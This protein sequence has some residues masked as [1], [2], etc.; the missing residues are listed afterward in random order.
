MEEV[1]QLVPT[2][3]AGDIAVRLI[4]ILALVGANGFFV[5]SEFALVGARRTR[6]DMLAEQGERSARLAQKAIRHLDH[7]LS[8]TQLGITLASLGLGW[9]GETT[10][11]SLFMQ[12]FQGLPAPWDVIATHAVA[13]TI[14]F[15][16]IT[17]LHIVL[18]ELAPKS[19]AILHPE[20]VS[21]WTAGPLIAFSIVLSPFIRALNGLAG[22]LLR[23]FGLS[24]PHEAERV[25]RPE[26]LE[27]LITQ[28]FEHGLMS[29]EP[30]DM[31]RGVFDL[32]ETT[33]AEIMT[34]RTEIVAVPR[35]GTID[36]VERLIAETGHSRIP[37]YRDSIDQ[38]VGVVLARD[39]W[40]ARFD[41]RQHLDLAEFVRPVPF[42]PESKDLEHLLRE[43]QRDGNHIVVVLDEYAGTAGLVTVEDIIEQIVGEIADEHESHWAE[44]EEEPDGRV[45]I[46][47]RV[48]VAD[49]NER[50]HLH[51]PE[52]EYTTVAGLVMGRLGRVAQVGEAVESAGG[53]FRVVAMSGRRIERVALE[54][55]DRGEAAP[56]G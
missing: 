1:E 54:R 36:E 35:T 11:S 2:L 15:A 41:R 16:L 22:L 55:T 6:I 28:S 30:V 34:S 18:G 8:G 20:R 3:E 56:G 31:I 38:I 5:A 39:L 33:A 37:V 14:A 24:A 21:M 4:I 42:V 25:H 40:R 43:M 29:Q 47:G 9:I 13:G 10:L 26:E 49:L 23:A 19:L 51:L 32:S 50:F 45:L 53:V 52:E 7:Y 27:T 17:V 48:L 44:I 46:A 12:W